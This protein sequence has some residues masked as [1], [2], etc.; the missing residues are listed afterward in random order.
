MIVTI[1][2]MSKVGLITTERDDCIEKR[3]TLILAMLVITFMV[4][5]NNVIYIIDLNGKILNNVYVKD[6]DL[7][8]LTKEE[9]TKR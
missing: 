2:I 6:I 5:N 3:Q 1:I 8:D 9:A 4:T 7:S